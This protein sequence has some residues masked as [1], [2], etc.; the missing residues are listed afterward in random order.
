MRDIRNSRFEK[1]ARFLDFNPNFELA[2]FFFAICSI[3]KIYINRWFFFAHATSNEIETC[4][5]VDLLHHGHEDTR[6]PMGEQSLLPPSAFLPLV[7]F[8]ILDG[9]SSSS[10]TRHMT[11]A[12]VISRDPGPSSIVDRWTF[13]RSAPRQRRHSNIASNCVRSQSWNSMMR[14]ALF[15]SA[16]GIVNLTR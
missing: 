11:C 9:S 8:I 15:S 3:P 2:L 7:L 10:L 12:N 14:G 4:E 1:D 5:S 13:Y 6:W 16:L